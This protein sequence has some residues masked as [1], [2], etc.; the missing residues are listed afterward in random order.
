[1]NLERF[2]C[3]RGNRKVNYANNLLILECKHAQQCP[4]H[5]NYGTNNGTSTGENNGTS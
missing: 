2:L 4:D 3:V 5:L 1:M